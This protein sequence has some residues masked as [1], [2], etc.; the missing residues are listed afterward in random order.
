MT[1]NCTRTENF[2]KCY[3]N[4]NKFLIVDLLRPEYEKRSGRKFERL[5]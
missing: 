4:V 3:R 5:Y 2:S 1:G